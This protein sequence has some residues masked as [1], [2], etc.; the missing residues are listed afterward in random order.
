MAGHPDG[1]RLCCLALI[2]PREDAR[3]P[4]SWMEK[5]HPPGPQQLCAVETQRV[6]VGLGEPHV[7]LL[8]CLEVFCVL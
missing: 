3:Q 6:S 1:C 8:S 4:G 7:A 5:A 2:E